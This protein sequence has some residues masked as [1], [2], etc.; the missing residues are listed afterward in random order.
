[1]KLNYYLLAFIFLA[2]SY[3]TP[4]FAIDEGH[5]TREQA[6]S[7]CPDTAN[8]ND[9]FKRHAPKIN[10]DPEG[11]FLSRLA[12]IFNVGYSG[13]HCGECG[14]FI[15]ACVQTQ[16]DLKRYFPVSDDSDTEEPSTTEPEP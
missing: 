7:V 1:M 6:A 15:R 3:S 4:T 13:V 10:T 8:I 12:A 2:S 9:C 16:H 14:E 11:G 5:C